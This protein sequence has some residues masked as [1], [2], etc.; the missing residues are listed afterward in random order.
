[1]RWLFVTFLSESS[2]TLK[3]TCKVNVS[4]VFRQW[5]SRSQGARFKAS[6][7]ELTYPDEDSFAL[8][9]DVGNGKLVGKRHCVERLN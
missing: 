9:V 3:S 7:V 8:Q 6:A 2:G 4:S 1:M 5:N